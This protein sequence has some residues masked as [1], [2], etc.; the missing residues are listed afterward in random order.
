[1][2]LVQITA[3]HFV[4]GLQAEDGRVV[5]AAPIIKYMIGWDGGGLK[6]WCHHKG[7]TYQVV[8][9]LPETERLEPTA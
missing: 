3:P 7:W 6:S 8:D 2:T 9:R 4:A 5:R 1:M